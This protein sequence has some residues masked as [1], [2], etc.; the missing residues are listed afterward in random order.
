MRHFA[1]DVVRRELKLAATL[2]RRPRRASSPYGRQWDESIGAARRRAGSRRESGVRECDP[3]LRSPARCSGE[4]GSQ[5]SM[6]HRHLTHTDDVED[7]NGL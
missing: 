6:D 3:T 1:A 7:R 4:A 5:S 2:R